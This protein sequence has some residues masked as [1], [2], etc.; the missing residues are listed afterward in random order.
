MTEVKKESPV[1]QIEEPSNEDQFSGGGHEQAAYAIESAIRCEKSIKSC[2]TLLG[3]EGDLGAGKSTVISLLKNRLDESYDFLEFDVDTHSHSSIKTALIKVLHDHLHKGPISDSQKRE[4]SEA[5]NLAIGN[6]LIYEKETNSKLSLFIVFM[7]VSM[8]LFVRYAVDGFSAFFDTLY[9]LLFSR[10]EY[11]FSGPETLKFI[12]GSSPFLMLLYKK[13]YLDKKR[14]KANESVI[15][16]ADIFKRNSKDTITETLD[17]TREVGSLELQEALSK[18]VLSIPDGRTLI[19]VVD[20]I[21]RVESNLIKEIWSDLNI[22]SS[23]KSEYLK[24]ILPFSE[25]HIAQALSDEEDVTYKSGREYISKRLPIVFRAPPIITAD[26]RV[27]FESYWNES[28]WFIKGCKEV[29][30]LIDIWNP[31]NTPVTP[32]FIKRLINDIATNYVGCPEKDIHGL[33]FAFYLLVYKAHRPYVNIYQ[34]LELQKNLAGESEQDNQTDDNDKFDERLWTERLLKSQSL[35]DKVLGVEVNWAEQIACINYQ[36][37]KSVA[38]SELLEKPIQEAVVNGNIHRFV[39]LSGVRGFDI[40][41]ERA[42]EKYAPEYLYNFLEEIFAAELIDS[43]DWMSNQLSP[44]NRWAKVCNDHIVPGSLVGMVSLKKQGF[45]VSL[46]RVEQEYSLYL[47]EDKGI[48]VDSIL[49]LHACSQVL[50]RVPNV[51]NKPAGDFYY[52]N[53]W[54]NEKLLKY[55]DVRNISLDDVDKNRILVL[56]RQFYNSNQRLHIDLELLRFLNSTY[57]VGEKFEKIAV[58]EGGIKGLFN[59]KRGVEIFPYTEVWG[60]SGSTVH[61]ISQ[62]AMSYEEMDDTFKQSWLSALLA[63]GLISNDL[64]RDFQVSDRYGTRYRNIYDLVTE[65]ISLDDIELEVFSFFLSHTS[66]QNILKFTEDSQLSDLVSRCLRI[67]I[68]NGKVGRI[69]RHQVINNKYNLIVNYFDSPEVVLEWLIPWVGSN[70]FNDLNSWDSQL[71][72]D[73]LQYDVNFYIDGFYECVESLELDA[74]KE[75]VTNP[76]CNSAKIVQYMVEDRYQ[77]DNQSKLLQTL[78]SLVDDA[79]GLQKTKP[80]SVECLMKLLS[81]EKI[82]NLTSK[83][84]SEFVKPDTSSEHR[85]AI[86]KNFKKHFNLPQADSAQLRHA[87]INLFENDELHQWLS[88]Q[89]WEFSTWDLQELR[90]LNTE[91]E[92]LEFDFSSINEQLSL[93]IQEIESELNLEEMEGE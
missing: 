39:E 61:L 9:I 7:A 81:I 80:T 87:Y 58:V 40:F 89:E 65:I 37:S 78:K 54:P 17:V 35:M 71:V 34:I 11:I 79:S 88:S 31:G 77:L 75:T 27:Q 23:L 20:N 32:R 41:F 76:N 15:N 21:D 56:A 5:K 64:T 63:H 24:V 51:V 67:Y 1:Y 46:V 70:D 59:D 66:F 25:I 44:V 4:L 13:Y 68:Q 6:T 90:A 16:F 93:R 2:P 72:L 86:I 12:A 30:E 33:C 82:D 85:V 69:H 36:T 92:S 38:N 45:P 53:L 22:L 42:V 50:E 47:S 74:W 19:L 8:L 84:Y 28:I 62:F 14:V 43:E 26:W 48:D 29:S 18:F 52:F 10:S 83:I 3:L 91:I 60:N 73:A 49:D 57:E 55:W